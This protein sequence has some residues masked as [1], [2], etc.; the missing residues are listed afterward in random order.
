MK[1][2]PRFLAWLISAVLGPGAN[3]ASAAAS[4]PNP[5]AIP[6]LLFIGDSLST[7]PFGERLLTS[8]TRGFGRSRVWFYAS[9]GSSVED[10]LSAE[11]VFHT[12]CGYRELTP[13]T[14]LREEYRDGRRPRPMPTPKIE[15]L[16]RKHHPAIVVVQ[17]GTN[18]FDDLERDGPD[19]LPRLEIIFQRFAGALVRSRSSVRRVVWITPPDSARYPEWIETAIDRLIR[20]VAAAQHIDVVESRKFTRY[21]A[22]RTG[23][24]GVH[25]RREPAEAWAVRVIA[26]L[27][28]ALG[29][30]G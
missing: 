13:E 5:A 21:V 1:R 28:R 8:F 4:S 19:A 29:T 30:G 11:P 25:Y 3:P 18:H 22:G 27:N 12:P 10:W 2:S 16:I 7:G 26:E 24:D 14:D 23:T 20:R 9:C 17:L 15:D 6:R